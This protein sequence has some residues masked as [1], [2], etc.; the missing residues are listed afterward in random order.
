MRAAVSSGVVGAL[1]GF[2]TRPCCI[3]PAALS[4]TGISAGGFAGVNVAY[5]SLFVA[6]SLAMM[7]AS[8]W[9]TFRREG[10]WINRSLSLAAV[11]VGFVA[12][13]RFLGAL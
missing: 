5:R 11:G 7:I 9:I 3:I 4:L 1:A 2:L 12:A 13:T 8:V 10:G 6:F